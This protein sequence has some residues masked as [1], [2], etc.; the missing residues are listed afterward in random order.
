MKTAAL[1]F[2]ILGFVFGL[3]A[4]SMVNN[5]KEELNARGSLAEEEAPVTQS[6]PRQTRLDKKGWTSASN[7]FAREET[8]GL[9]AQRPPPRQ[10]KD[11]LAAAKGHRLEALF[12]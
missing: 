12:A 2:G 9:H 6:L 1:T 8:L 5:L 11:F 7:S 4:V 10:A 3:V